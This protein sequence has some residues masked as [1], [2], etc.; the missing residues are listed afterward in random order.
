MW[1]MR[2][3]QRNKDNGGDF[4]V[5]SQEY[6]GASKDISAL[7][8]TAKDVVRGKDIVEIHIFQE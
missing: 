7:L 5:N 2:I 6:A 1:R 8:D 3:V 4:S